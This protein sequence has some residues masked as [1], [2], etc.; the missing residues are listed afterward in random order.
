M[1]HT[2]I[3]A[4]L[5]ACGGQPAN[6]PGNTTNSTR[7]TP[8]ILS[9]SGDAVAGR[10]VFEKQ[11]CAVC[12]STGTDQI[13][14]PGMAGLFSADGP[15]LPP[16]VDYQ[17]NLPNGQPHTEQAVAAFIRSNNRGQ[18]GFM[19]GRTMSDAD[20]ADLLAYLRTLK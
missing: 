20:M 17:G 8:L 14:G 18:I 19:M 16:G 10:I 7:P 6:P 3:L 1:T 9:A 11:G 12:H 4:I 13:V 15:I 2:V 5:I